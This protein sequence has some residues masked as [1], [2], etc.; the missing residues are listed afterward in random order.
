MSYNMTVI[1]RTMVDAYGWRTD[2]AELDVEGDYRYLLPRVRSGGDGSH[3]MIVGLNPASAGAIGDPHKPDTTVQVVEQWASHIGMFAQLEHPLNYSR[4]TFVNLFAFRHAKPAELD[5]VLAPD[6]GVDPVGQRNLDVVL[7]AADRR[8][9]TIVVSWG[10][11]D[12]V[13]NFHDRVDDQRV[14]IKVALYGRALQHVGSLTKPRSTV[15]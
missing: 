4:I 1:R 15:D 10:D 13:V 12:E 11:A 14:A 7:T 2:E 8:P 3:L 9:E 5:R 6:S